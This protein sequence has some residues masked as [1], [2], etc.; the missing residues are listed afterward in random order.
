MS[1]T[2]TEINKV[3]ILIFGI[4]D[5]R[6]GPGRLSIRQRYIFTTILAAAIHGSF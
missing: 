2:R 6:E 4:E 3:E 5:R 1:M